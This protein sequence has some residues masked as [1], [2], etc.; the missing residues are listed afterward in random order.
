MAPLSQRPI[1]LMPE[2]MAGCRG[3][4]VLLEWSCT[5]TGLGHAVGQGK[6]MQVGK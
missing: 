6:G 4:P 5:L 2:P 1:L 3:I